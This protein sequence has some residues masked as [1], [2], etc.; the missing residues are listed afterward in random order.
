MGITVIRLDFYKMH[1]LK[2]DIEILGRI[3]QKE[4]QAGQLID[5]YREKMEFIKERLKPGCKPPDVYMEN[6]SDYH[7]VGPGSGADE[8]CALSGGHNISS[9]FA[10]PY[11]E[12]TP[13]WVLTKNPEIIIKAVSFCNCYAMT[14]TNKLEGA[15]KKI[16]KRP[17]WDNIRAVRE[18][19]VY[20][21]AGD[22]WT[23]PTAV[24]GICYMAKWFY[25]DF[26]NDLDPEKIHKEYL[27]KFQRVSYRGTYVYPY[28]F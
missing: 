13:E 15:R 14:G 4:K 3:L 27:E 24:V 12:V 11:P 7:S 20:V 16:L 25:P 6:Y 8:M 1:R 10:I 19:K 18:G 5:W 2:Q 17:A 22:I 26:F 9:D 23:G 21:M 28:N